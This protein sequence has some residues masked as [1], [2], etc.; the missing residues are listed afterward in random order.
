MNILQSPANTILFS[1]ISLFEITIK[2]K[3]GKLSQFVATIQD[4]FN[5]ANLDGFTFLPI[6]NN[7]LYHYNDI[8]LFEQH[9]DPFDRLLLATALIEKVSILSADANFNLYKE[10]V[11]VIW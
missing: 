3:V 4:V 8:L 10:S 6:N 1:Q 9:R 5:Q 7:H 2:Q 11:T